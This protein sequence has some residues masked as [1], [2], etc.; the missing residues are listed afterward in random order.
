MPV[1]V[2]EIGKRQHAARFY[3]EA[4][5]IALRKHAAPG[6][7]RFQLRQRAEAD[8]RLVAEKIRAAA[9]AIVVPIDGG[10]QTV[11]LTVSVGGAAYP[12]D[13]TTAN[14]LLATADAALYDAKHAGRNRVRMAG[15]DDADTDTEVSSNVTSVVRPRRSAQ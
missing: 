11:T 4:L 1:A 10:R 5:E 6:G 2:R 9:E 7:E 14:E 13:T 15:D 12:E 8:A 3:L